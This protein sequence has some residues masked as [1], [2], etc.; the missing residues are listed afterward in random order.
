MTPNQRKQHTDA[1]IIAASA[2]RKNWLGK[3][4]PINSVQSA[5][6]K[7]L[8]AVWG[9]CYGGRTTEEAMMDGCGFWSC[10]RSEEWSDAEACRITETIKDLRKIG[11]TGENL[12]KMAHAILWPQKSLADAIAGQIRQDDTDF[13]EKSILAALR[14]DDPVYVVGV[15]FYAR[16]KNVS[17]IGR[18]LQKVAPWLTR[19]QAEDRVRWCISHFNCAVFLSMRKNIY[20]VNGK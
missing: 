14:N 19:K 18:Y 8:L 11:Y 15:D 9:E 7:S 17:D 3:H 4:R 10:L 5:W 13:V 2:P 6:V 1:M 16:R 20:Q 12:L